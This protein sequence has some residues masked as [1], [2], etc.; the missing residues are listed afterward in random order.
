MGKLIGEMKEGAVEYVDRVPLEEGK[1]SYGKGE[2]KKG[3][4]K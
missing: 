4:V 1:K 3:Y 2:G